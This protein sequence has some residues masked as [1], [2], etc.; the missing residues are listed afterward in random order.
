LSSKGWARFSEE[1]QIQ[2]NYDENLDY[3]TLVEMDLF[4][5]IYKY[6]DESQN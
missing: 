1:N 3:S 2:K 5:S 6:L 4:K